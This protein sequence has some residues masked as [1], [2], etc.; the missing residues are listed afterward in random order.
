MYGNKVAVARR[1]R[2]GLLCIRSESDKGEFAAVAINHLA[3]PLSVQRST[4]WLKVG[5]SVA[6]EN[7]FEVSQQQMRLGVALARS[8]FASVSMHLPQSP[9]N[10]NRVSVEII[11]LPFLCGLC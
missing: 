1:F 2:I 7:A 6:S 9:Q 5:A 8:C 3:R 4:A 10:R 11:F